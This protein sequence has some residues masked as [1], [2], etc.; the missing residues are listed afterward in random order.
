MVPTNR[1]TWS[2]F[3]Q[4]TRVSRL[5]L[6]C[7]LRH[8]ARRQQRR[9]SRRTSCGLRWFCSGCNSSASYTCSSRYSCCCRR[10][11]C[12]IWGCFLVHYRGWRC[13]KAVVAVFAEAT[14]AYGA[15]DQAQMVHVTALL[16][17]TKYRP[18]LRASVLGHS[19]ACASQ[20][21]KRQRMEHNCCKL[22]N[23]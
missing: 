2:R 6:P 19:T 20:N 12:T 13:Q 22:L 5:F 16:A 14:A 10:R 7:N 23:Y 1:P 15:S 9:G 21:K 8:R 3:L 4:Y 18:A 11:C 17:A